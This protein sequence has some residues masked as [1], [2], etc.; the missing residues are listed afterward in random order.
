MNASEALAADATAL[1]EARASGLI[2]ARPTSGYTKWSPVVE[3]ALLESFCKGATVRAACAAARISTFT[4]YE[5]VRMNDPFRERLTVVREGVIGSVEHS[6]LLACV[7]PDKHGRVDVQAIKYFLNNRAADRYSEKVDHI[8][9]NRDFEEPVEVGSEKLTFTK[10]QRERGK[11]L[12]HEL[13]LGT[14]DVEDAEIVDQ[15]KELPY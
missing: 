5:N 7:M 1:E 10:E 15:S 2:V 8:H 9:H 4:F 14:G 11:A 12:A 3:A 13:I 6:L